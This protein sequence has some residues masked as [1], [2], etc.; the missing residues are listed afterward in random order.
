[1]GAWPFAIEYSPA[2][3]II[4]EATKENFSRLSGNKTSI[5]GVI[6]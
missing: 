2:P 3:A 6:T 1:M 4:P 5:A